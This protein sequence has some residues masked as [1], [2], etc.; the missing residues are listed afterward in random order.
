MATDRFLLVLYNHTTNRKYLEICNLRAGE[1]KE[2][3]PSSTTSHLL[4]T[5]YVIVIGYPRIDLG[6][7]V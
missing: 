4:V 2:V 3:D 1:R 7:I 5:Y 6:Y